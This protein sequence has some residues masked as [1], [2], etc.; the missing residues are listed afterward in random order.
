MY[1]SQHDKEQF[2]DEDESSGINTS[3]PEEKK[4]Y[5][6]NRSAEEFIIY[7]YKSPMYFA[8]QLAFNISEKK[9]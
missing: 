8:N 1:N 9:I 2:Q 4:S 6:R 3:D 7:S 5:N